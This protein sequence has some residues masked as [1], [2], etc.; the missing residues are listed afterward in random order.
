MHTDV[1]CGDG[2]DLRHP[3]KLKVSNLHQ[4]DTIPTKGSGVKK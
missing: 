4:R 3:L 2:A 1:S